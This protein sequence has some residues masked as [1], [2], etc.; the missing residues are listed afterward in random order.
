MT[1]CILYLRD[2]SAI[3]KRP[4]AGVLG[5]TVARFGLDKGTVLFTCSERLFFFELKETYQ[6][7]SGNFVAWLRV[8][9]GEMQ[10]SGRLAPWICKRV[11]PFKLAFLFCALGC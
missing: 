3:C 9:V 11:V 1:V 10:A 7:K 4:I 5:K 2:H 6:I 8:L